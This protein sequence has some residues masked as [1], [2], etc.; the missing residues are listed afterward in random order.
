MGLLLLVYVWIAIVL[1]WALSIAVAAGIGHLL[2]QR[3]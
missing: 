3:R 1:G 2:A